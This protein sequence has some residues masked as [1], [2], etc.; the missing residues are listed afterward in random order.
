VP[1][2]TEQ[3]ILN[4]R[5]AKESGDVL[6]PI[7]ERLLEE[8]CEPEDSEDFLFMQMLL[9]ARAMP[10]AKGIFSPSMLGSCVR[11]AYFAKTGEDAWKAHST[12]TNGY[13]LKGNFTHLQ[14]QFAT[15]K[16]HRAGLLELVT[17][18]IEEEWDFLD[19]LYNEG[20]LDKLEWQRWKGA[21]NFYGNGTRP[22]VELRVVSKSGDFGGT[23]DEV[24][25]LEAEPFVVDVKGINQIEYQRAIK[26]GI[27]IEYR[28]QIVGYAMLLNGSHRFPFAVKRAILL[29][30]NKAGPVSGAKSPLALHEQIVEVDDYKHVV[31]RK[32][33]RLREYVAQEIL[34]P[35]AC[36]S[37]R[38]M[39]FQECAFNRHCRAEVKAIQIERE[40]DTEK[41]IAKWKVNKV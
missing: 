33:T 19:M 16:A 40:R 20:Q 13:F 38:H 9:R 3:R 18:D 1:T 37:T 15:W 21:L 29:S 14:W 27:K 35:P 39:G 23:V 4:R 28:V 12:Q 17:V 5:H 10:R 41:S 11:Q 8:E 30:E 34:P 36:V 7:L 26:N 2:P 25:K 6:R 31:R 24:V 22:A 32:L